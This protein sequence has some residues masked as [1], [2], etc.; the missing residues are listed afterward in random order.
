MQVKASMRYYLTPVKI[1]VT[2]KK[3]KK[4]A[5]VAENVENRESL[6]TVCKSVN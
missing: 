1:A 6:C 5:S 2:K 4:K 3:K